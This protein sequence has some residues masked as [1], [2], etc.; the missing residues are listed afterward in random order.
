MSWLL[1]IIFISLGPLSLGLWHRFRAGSFFGRRCGKAPNVDMTGKVVLVTGG[2]R[3]IGKQTALAIKQMNANVAVLDIGFNDME[4]LAFVEDTG[5]EY[6]ECDLSSQRSIENFVRQFTFKHKKLDVLCNNAGIVYSGGL[7]TKVTE[8]GFSRVIGINFLGPFLLTQLLATL[9]LASPCGRVVNV[10]SHQHENGTIDFENLQSFNL[11]DPLPYANSK[12]CLVLMAKKL[13]RILTAYQQKG[14]ALAVHPGAVYSTIHKNTPA[15]FKIFFVPFAWLFFRSTMEGAQ[16]S[17]F[18]CTYPDEQRR[19][20]G[21]YMEHL[22]VSTSKNPLS[23]DE[24]LQDRLWVAALDLCFKGNSKE[25]C[26]F[27]RLLS[28][29]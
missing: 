5:L 27:T 18:A 16:T 2:A 11:M 12:L 9:L 1:W 19:L 17:I 20:G 14:E 26:N 29:H 7:N 10:A 24:E 23:N 4:K 6:F 21:T 22:Q 8:D 15:I 3:G 25:K 28:A 13:N